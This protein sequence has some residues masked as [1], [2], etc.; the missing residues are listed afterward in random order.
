[1]GVKGMI[2]HPWK[3]INHLGMGL[4]GYALRKGVQY[5]QPLHG[6][7]TGA[8]SYN[9]KLASQSI[10]AVGILANFLPTGKQKIRRLNFDTK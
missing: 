10:D 9:R 6:Y 7:L 8:S 2:G 3:A 4:L 5:W 1:M